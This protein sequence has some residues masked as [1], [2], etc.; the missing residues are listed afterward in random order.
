MITGRA[1][2]QWPLQGKLPSRPWIGWSLCCLCRRAAPNVTD[3]STIVM[4]HYRS[5]PRLTPRPAKCL[6]KTTTRHSSEEFV[7]FLADLAAHQLRQREIHSILDNFSAHK[8]ER[9]KQ[10]LTGHPNVHIHYTPTYSS[11]LNQVELWFARIERDVIARAVFIQPKIFVENSCDTFGTKMRIQ[12]RSN[13][14]TLMSLTGLSVPVHLLQA[15][16][17]PNC[18]SCCHI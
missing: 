8:T 11:W 15:A 9:V 18:D 4:G 3:L 16:R 1:E 5:T 17:R 12:N 13:G 6:V 10:F 14:P 2:F 7:A